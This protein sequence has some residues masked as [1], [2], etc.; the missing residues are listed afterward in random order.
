MVAGTPAQPFLELENAR[1]FGSIRS[2]AVSAIG[3]SSTCKRS[4][5]PPSPCGSWVRCGPSSGAL[6]IPYK[7]NQIAALKSMIATWVRLAVFEALSGEE[8][9]DQRLWFVMDE[10]DALGAIDGIRTPWP[11]F[12]NSAAPSWASNRL[13]KAPA[14]TAW[15]TREPSSRTAEYR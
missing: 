11:G 1:M 6:F 5:R 10:L 2:V 13:R 8:N 9:K 15:E 7:A 3:L 14:P 12:A 4:G